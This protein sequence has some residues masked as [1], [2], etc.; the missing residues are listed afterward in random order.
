MQRIFKDNL[1]GYADVAQ[2]IYNRKIAGYFGG[3]II[4]N[5]LGKQQYE[6]VFN[7]RSDWA[8]I[9]DID[10][11]TIA[12]TNYYKKRGQSPNAQNTKNALLKCAEALQNNTY[13]EEA[14]KFIGTRTEFLAYTPTNSQAV[15][16]VE[17]SPVKLNNSFFWRYRG[18][19]IL[20]DKNVVA[21]QYDFKP[22]DI[23]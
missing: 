12:V 20:Y 7:N 17:R 8:N 4:G 1:Q 23:A 16:I 15:G 18:K 11:A 9:Y 5:I 2:S 21:T 13:K 3:S 22:N 10:T 14:R 6:P 19:D